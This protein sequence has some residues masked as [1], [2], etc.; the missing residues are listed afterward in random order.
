MQCDKLLYRVSVSEFSYRPRIVDEQIAGA[1]RRAGAVLIEG[2]KACGKTSSAMQHARSSV[3]LD[4]NPPLRTAALS[5]ASILLPGPEP[6][7]IDEWQLVP[8]VWNV[9]RAEVDDRQRDGQ[10]ILTGSATPADDATR[11]TGAMRIARLR[12][13]PMSLFESR[14]STGTLSLRALLEGEAPA[15][16][17]SGAT[18]HDIAGALCRGGWP[19]NLRR[20]TADAQAA[21]TDYLRT[22]SAADLPGEPRR[23]PVKLKALLRALA[24]SVAT[25][26]SNTTLIRD[27]NAG[28]ETLNPRTL[29]TYLDALRRLWV[30]DE[31]AAWGGHLR[32]SAPA[33][34][35]PKRHLVDPSL[36]AAALGATPAALVEDPET[37]GLLFESLAFR[38]LSIYAQ[39]SGWQP[40]AF[41]TPASEIDIVLVKDG[42]WAG[43]EVKLTGG[44]PAVLDAAAAELLK[45]ARSMRSSPKALTVLTATGP[46]YRRRDG[47]NVVSLTEL[48]P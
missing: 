13:H 41:Q 26:V 6:R 38:D 11:H 5:D 33:R 7:L 4:A 24:R 44:N 28:G 37:F 45:A 3:R 20:T 23:D 47:V 18:M 35:A 21:N 32:S 30:L 19:S 10:F 46:S 43:F 34:K 25:Y 12:M 9:V 16:S 14:D 2:P 27:V 40:F 36:A 15:S 42:R 17:G 31:Q 1:L 48:A 8:D 22:M 39:A 29:T